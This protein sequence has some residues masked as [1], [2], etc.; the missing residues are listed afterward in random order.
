MIQELVENLEEQLQDISKH[1]PTIKAFETFI[2]KNS[3]DL[4]LKHYLNLIGK[5][6]YTLYLSQF[7]DNFQLKEISLSFYLMK[8]RSQEKIARKLSGLARVIL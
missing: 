3:K 5:L 1:G 2:R 4:H 8:R 7:V 6:I